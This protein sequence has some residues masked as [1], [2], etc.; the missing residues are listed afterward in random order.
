MIVAWLLLACR[1]DLPV[2]DA[3]T[4]GDVVGAWEEVLYEVVTDDG[5]VDYDRLAANRHALD[6]YVAHLARPD[7]VPIESRRRL[8]FWL[9][10]YNALVMVSVLDT[11]RPASV[12]DVPGWLPIDGAGFFYLR[13]WRIGRDRLSLWDVK[14]ERIRIRTMDY[15]VH[16]AVNDGTRSGPPLRDE[17]YRFPGLERQLDDQMARWVNDEARGVRVVDGVAELPHEFSRY[18]RD[19]SFWWGNADPCTVAA[20][21]ADDALAAELT[22]LAAEG[23][24]R[25]FRAEDR[26]L[27][28]GAGGDKP[29]R[30]RPIAS[31]DDAAEEPAGEDD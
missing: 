12:D 25:R 17:L 14:H 13:A 21:H 7:V 15:R 1:T 5:L 23:C 30:E 29:P 3:P 2:P 8:A 18:A 27:N 24:P 20:R 10:T 4:D 11:G 19:F 31:D 9:N 28:H 26:A 16:G 6:A 22:A